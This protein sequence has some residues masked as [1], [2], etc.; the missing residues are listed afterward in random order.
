MV[1]LAAVAFYFSVTSTNKEV[2]RQTYS[3]APGTT[4]EPSFVT[5]TFELSGRPNNIR[6]EIDT[7]LSNNWAYF[8]LALIEQDT[9]RGYDFGREVS[10]YYGRD[11]DGNWS[12][13]KP[14]N[15]VTVPDVAPGRYYLRVEPEM[16][17][18]AMPMR[19]ELV[20]R[21]G[22]ITWTWI[23]LAA[24]LLAVPPIYLTVRGIA[25]E[26]ARYRQG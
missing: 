2:F 5:P 16:D 13:G 1:A 9:G 22:V 24:L 14:K 10:Y 4:S 18:N 15:S 23:W 6:I 12:E 26:S 17:A 25:F 20:V 21:R 7:D 19:Y 8:N 11:S 3:F